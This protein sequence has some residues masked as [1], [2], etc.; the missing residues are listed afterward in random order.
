MRNRHLLF[1]LFISLFVIVPCEAGLKV[2]YIRHAEGG[3][4][5]VKDWALVPREQWPD[6]VGR[7]DRFTPLGLEQVAKVPEKL[8]PY[9]FDFIAVSPLWRTRH[10][11]LPYLQAQQLKAEIWPELAEFGGLPMTLIGSPHLPAPQTELFTGQ[12]IQ[13][14]GNET[15]YFTL[16]DDGRREF[17]LPASSAQAAA[18]LQAILEKNVKLIRK[19]FGGTE[20]SILLVGHGNNG[21]QL[22]RTLTGNPDDAKVGIRNTG[23]WMVEE[24][25]DGTFKLILLNDEPVKR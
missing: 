14:A 20:K 24:Q 18:N 11:I 12:E 10:T 8:K 2:Y 19:R 16:R 3:H 13:V 9:T 22:L 21:R 4:N 23:I 6:Y 17:K 25:K 7:A 5:V 15:S 1:L